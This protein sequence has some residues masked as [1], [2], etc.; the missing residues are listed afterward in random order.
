MPSPTL[1]VII[2]N[3]N[4]AERLLQCLDALFQGR[5]SSPMEIIVV[6]N[7]SRDDSV[8]RV[9]ESYPAVRIISNT[10]NRGFAGGANDG[11]R[12]SSGRLVLILNPDV[13]A[14]PGSLFDLQKYLDEHPEAGAVMPLLLGDDGRT[15][16]EY[17]RQ[18]PGL[19]QCLLFNTEF[20][21]FAS[22]SIRVKRRYLLFPIPDGSE[23][24]SIAQ[25][26]GACILTRR[27]VWDSVGG[28]DESYRL[29]FE[30]VEWSLQVVRRGL[31]LVLHPGITVR[32]GGG[33]SFTPEHD[34]WISAR[35]VL[36][37]VEYFRRHH[38][39]PTA[40]LVASIL[41]IN[42]AAVIAARSV[43]GPFVSAQA[44]K[45]LVHQAARQS[46]IL[47]HLRRRWL[48]DGE[49]ELPT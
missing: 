12:E 36:S 22:S 30:D 45:T 2:V 47:F 25:I 18:L 17:V 38:G 24:F 39:R 41:V 14:D 16:P 44:R 3:W 46:C 35:Y 19:M 48:H 42:A 1:S 5:D 13:V 26:A 8:T 23:P 4:T 34:E 37:M 40:F 9:R 33:K 32:H 28:M 27:E 43:L 10:V 49:L 7:A 11:V 31:S 21:R 15:Q 29:F 6:D 20:R